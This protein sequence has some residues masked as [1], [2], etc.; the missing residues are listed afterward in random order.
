MA[1]SLLNFGSVALGETLQIPVRNT[2]WLAGYVDVYRCDD[3]ILVV[4]EQVPSLV[5]NFSNIDVVQ[6]EIDTSALDSESVPAAAYRVGGTYVVVI[7]EVDTT[8]DPSTNFLL[9]YFTVTFN[10]EVI[11]EKVDGMIT[12]LHDVLAKVT[13]VLGLEAENIVVDTIV[14]DAN[15]N[16]TSARIRLFDTGANAANATLGTEVLEV[17]EIARYTMAQTFNA[18]RRIRSGFRC[19]LTW[20]LSTEG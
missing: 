18:P 7:K 6:F 14:A 13:R 2:G 19:Y 11:D 12:D 9:G 17:G 4:D 5:I 10:P 16:P 3:G 8:Y 15:G 1:T 20:K